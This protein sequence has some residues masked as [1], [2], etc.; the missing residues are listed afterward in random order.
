MCVCVCVHCKGYYTLLLPVPITVTHCD[1]IGLHCVIG[2]VT[3]HTRHHI[4]LVKFAHGAIGIVAASSQDDG[5]TLRHGLVGVVTVTETR[6]GNGTVWPGP[7]VHSCKRPSGGICPL[8]SKPICASFEMERYKGKGKRFALVVD[9]GFVA[10]TVVHATLEICPNPRTVA[11]TRVVL[12]VGVAKVDGFHRTCSIT[13]VICF[14]VAVIKTTAPVV[15]RARHDTVDTL[16]VVACRNPR[17]LIHMVAV[18]RVKPHAI[19]LLF[20]RAYQDFVLGCVDKLMPL[21]EMVL[22]GGLVKHVGNDTVPKAAKLF[23]GRDVG[24]AS[25]FQD[26]NVHGYA[27]GSRDIVERS[28]IRFV[29]STHRAVSRHTRVAC[30]HQDIA[31]ALG[32]QRWRRWGLWW[33]DTGC[34]KHFN[35]ILCPTRFRGIACACLV[36]VCHGRLDC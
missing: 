3:G 25:R 11:C 1:N 23:V 8:E 31:R 29:E 28:V 4:T 18:P 33:G 30:S 12:P 22:H 32:W 5:P 24:K 27:I 17:G 19:H 16:G 9:F 34:R 13:M 10:S 26:T 15:V 7:V 21:A 2:G 6:A 20:V 36:A 35:P 14:T